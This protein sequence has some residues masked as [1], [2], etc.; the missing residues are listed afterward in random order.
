M[1]ASMKMAMPLSPCVLAAMLLL[2]ASA[3]SAQTTLMAPSPPT[4]KPSAESIAAGK[5]AYM[6]AG[7]YQ[8]HGTVGHG[9]VGP[10]LAPAPM[11]LEAMTAFVRYTSRNMPAYGPELL[12]DADLKNIHAYLGTMEPPAKIDSMP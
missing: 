2:A 3:A 5:L 12:S 1:S 9:G 4:A 10:K 6:K 8:C 7:C 11:P